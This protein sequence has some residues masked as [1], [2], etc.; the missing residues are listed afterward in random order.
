VA[1][2]D[3][4]QVTFGYELAPFEV[5]VAFDARL[6]VRKVA[7]TLDDKVFVPPGDLDVRRQI[8]HVST[9]P[10]KVDRR[11]D[12]DAR[13][14]DFGDLD[15]VLINVE[16]LQLKPGVRLLGCVLN[17]DVEVLAI[18]DL[19]GRKS[20]QLGFSRARPEVAC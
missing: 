13:H 5:V 14:L 16:E 11:H 4:S 18:V 3:R 17:P 12:R 8:V 9:D 20:A 2:S 19:V 7:V 1:V 10:L 6:L 15:L